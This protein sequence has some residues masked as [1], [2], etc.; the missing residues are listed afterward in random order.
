MDTVARARQLR[1]EMTHAERALWAELRRRRLGVRWR[2]Q[3]VLRG[4]IL[5]F[6]A[7]SAGLVVE[8]DGASHADRRD[9]DRR[10]DAALAALGLSVMRVTNDEVLWQIERVVARVRAALAACGGRGA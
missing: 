3:H 4:F 1:R 8:V 7:P 9:D 6:F 2:R 5:D 10:R